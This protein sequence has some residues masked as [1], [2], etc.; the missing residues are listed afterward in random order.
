MPVSC[1]FLH[2]RAPDNATTLWWKARTSVD[3]TLS[4]RNLQSPSWEASD[5]LKA[6]SKETEGVL[7]EPTGTKASGNTDRGW[8]CGS[9]T[10][11]TDDPDV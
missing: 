10:A 3:P 1:P 8:L 6:M 4:L 2:F 9:R 7:R 11:P 5:L